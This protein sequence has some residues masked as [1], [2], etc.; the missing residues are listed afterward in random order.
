MFTRLILLVYSR[1]GQ[2]PNRIQAAE[3]SKSSFAR[4]SFAES[5]GSSAIREQFAKG[6][7][8]RFQILHGTSIAGS[9]ERIKLVTYLSFGVNL[10]SINEN[11]EC[12][13]P[14]R[15]QPNRHTEFTLDIVLKAHGLRFDITSK[16]AAFDLDAHTWTEAGTD[17]PKQVYNFLKFLVGS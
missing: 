11:I 13:R 6:L 3:R 4:V 14:A 10:F 17:L 8:S 5:Y 2:R 12:T 9:L 16:K 15:T 7:F 1:F